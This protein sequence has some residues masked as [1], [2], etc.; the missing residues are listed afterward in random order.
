MNNLFKIWLKFAIHTTEVIFMK[1]TSETN[2][3]HHTVQ[4]TAEKFF[5]IFLIEID[6]K[7]Q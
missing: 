3:L 7:K 1:R 6:H 4:K 5:F 2:C